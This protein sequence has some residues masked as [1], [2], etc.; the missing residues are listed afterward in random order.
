MFS[1]RESALLLIIN[2]MKYSRSSWEELDPSLFPT[3]CANTTADV[4]NG[5]INKKSTK[6]AGKKDKVETEVV[7]VDKTNSAVGRKSARGRKAH[8]KDEVVDV[9][10]VG[11]EDVSVDE[12]LLEPVEKKRKVIIH[13]AKGIM[14][15]S[16]P[17][18]ILDLSV[19]NAVAVTMCYVFY[20]GFRP[21]V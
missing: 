15:H 3:T 11:I 6:S 2:T 4:N 21:C 17:D 7:V 20:R 18:V 12:L 16:S 10:D 14:V 9:I 1:I 5:V 13:K 8:V 19:C